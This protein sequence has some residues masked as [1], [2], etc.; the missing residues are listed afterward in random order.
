MLVQYL[1]ILWI[2][3]V[4]TFTAKNKLRYLKNSRP[5]LDND[6]AFPVHKRLQAEEGVLQSGEKRGV[7]R[8]K[9]DE[10]SVKKSEIPRTKVMKKVKFQGQKWWKSVLKQRS[11]RHPK[12][13]GTHSKL[14]DEIT[15]QWQL[16]CWRKTCVKFA[17]IESSV[18]SWS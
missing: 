10:K 6:W 18:K 13:W 9:S 15:W 14:F 2:L 8:I 11:F 4:I 17:T 16:F 7:P 12:R 1:W 3:K 5:F